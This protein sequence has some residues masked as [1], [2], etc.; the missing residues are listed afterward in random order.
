V[1]RD[2]LSPL[3][4][5]RP[6]VGEAMARNGFGAGLR[7]WGVDYLTTSRAQPQHLYDVTPI[8][9]VLPKQP[10]LHIEIR[11]ERSCATTR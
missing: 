3:R 2:S 10:P 1:T 5:R 6:K 11:A 4:L 9:P 8:V 7:G